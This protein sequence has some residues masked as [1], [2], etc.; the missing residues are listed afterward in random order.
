MNGPIRH[1][2]GSTI[3]HPLDLI[4]F[5]GVAN[6]NLLFEP[7]MDFCLG[8]TPL[9]TDPPSGQPP[10]NRHLFDLFGSQVQVFS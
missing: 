5:V 8:K 3:Q 10:P 1:L 2:P 4:Q 9:A 7:V 6:A